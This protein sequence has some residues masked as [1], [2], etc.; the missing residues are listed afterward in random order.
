MSTLQRAIEI[1]LEGHKG[2]RDK[3]GALYILHPLRVMLAQTSEEARVVGVLHDVVED[4]DGWSF[5]RLRAEGFSDA[6]IDAL[7]SVT[8]RPEEE[9]DYA[10]FIARASS[11]PIGRMVK[12]ADLRD[13]CDL[14]RIAEPT[15]NDR[16]R[17]EK[18]CRAI[19]QLASESLAS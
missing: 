11:N 8:K 1:A 5:D 15:Q 19:A 6:V 7:A 4:C 13:N 2:Q 12:L 16:H 3:A 14:G 9:T 18:Y 10:A 17:V